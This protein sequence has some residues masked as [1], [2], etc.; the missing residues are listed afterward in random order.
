MVIWAHVAAMLGLSVSTSNTIA[1][2]Q[3]EIEKSYSH[4][5][6][7][8]SKECKSLKTSPLEEL[9]TIL[10]AWFKQARTTNASI[11]GSHLKEKA[12]HVAAHLTDLTENKV[13]FL[14]LFKDHRWQENTSSSSMW[15]MTYQ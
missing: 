10:S 13:S 12:L 4:C 6:P 15:R 1:S 11:N 9:E 7:S 8:F 3:S 5:G 14:I 2:K